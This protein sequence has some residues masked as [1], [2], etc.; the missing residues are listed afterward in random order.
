MVSEAVDIWEELATDGNVE[1]VVELEERDEMLLPHGSVEKFN[2]HASK[3][4]T[5]FG[6]LLLGNSHAFNRSLQGR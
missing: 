5:D 3:N 1:G 4:L 6:L 2:H